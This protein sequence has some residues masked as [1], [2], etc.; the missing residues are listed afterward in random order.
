MALV[1]K[2]E[3][4]GSYSAALPTCADA[5]RPFT[6]QRAQKLLRHL[7]MSTA[8]IGGLLLLVPAQLFLSLAPPHRPS[9]VG[10][11][12][13][14]ILLWGLRLRVVTRGTLHANALVV[15]NHIS[16]TDI[17]VLGSLRPMQFVAKAE[18]RGWPFL[19]WL[20]RL[21]ATL[22]V[23]RD[24]RRRTEEQLAA[25]KEALAHGPVALF[26]EGTTGCGGEV[27]P[28][29]PALLAAASHGFVQPVSIQYR[30]RDR[31]WHE[32]ELGAFA[33]DGDKAFLPHLLDVTAGRALDCLVI[34]HSPI[35][36][37]REG[38]KHLAQ[39]C[40]RIITGA[41]VRPDSELTA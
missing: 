17:L 1:V 34:A 41:L 12:Y 16:W 18:V 15:A 13:L 28:F 37:T 26:P 4:L 33:W 29:K 8:L 35:P 38:R 32:G 22:F 14:R 20:A 5:N 7:R 3:T 21:N 36:A 11:L 31:N 2:R 24:A 40:H 19:G 27:L 30:P 10:Q 9:R 6:K 25:M 39:E 23:E